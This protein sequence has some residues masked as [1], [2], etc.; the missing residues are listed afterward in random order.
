MRARST[1]NKPHNERLA[2]EIAPLTEVVVDELEEEEELDVA[3]A[4]AA[5]VTVTPVTLVNEQLEYVHDVRSVTKVPPVM[6][7]LRVVAALVAAAELWNA[8]EK[9]TERSRRREYELMLQSFAA[10]AVAP[11]LPQK[12][13]A[14]AAAL[15][16]NHAR[17]SELNCVAVTPASVTEEDTE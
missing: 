16:L 9:V 13:P 11:S 1:T 12:E 7:V 17:D 14:P 8:I 6:Y 3:V 15:D 5:D 2:A 4:T 10:Q